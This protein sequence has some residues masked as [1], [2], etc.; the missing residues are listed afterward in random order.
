[1]RMIATS[2]FAIVQEALE[3]S[4]GFDTA[5]LDRIRILE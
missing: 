2:S 1:M 3:K 4:S 5:A